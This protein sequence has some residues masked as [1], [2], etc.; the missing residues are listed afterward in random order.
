MDESID[1][2]KKKLEQIEKKKFAI[3][4]AIQSLCGSVIEG[5]VNLE[6]YR[7]RKVRDSL[8]DEIVRINRFIHPDIIA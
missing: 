8:Q 3:D 4:Q 6:F 5:S 1:L 2:L 7:L